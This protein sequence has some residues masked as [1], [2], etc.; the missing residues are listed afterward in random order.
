[1]ISL[2]YRLL[3]GSCVDG[4]RN[5][6]YGPPMAKVWDASLPEGGNATPLLADSVTAL[7]SSAVGRVVVCGSHAGRF[8]A[9]VAARKQVRG[10]VL[11]DAGV[12]LDRAGIAGLELLADLGV[13]AVTV[14]KD[15]AHIGDARDSLDRGIVSHLNDTA[16]ALGC[17]VGMPV[18]EAI[19]HLAA[20]PLASSTPPAIEEARHLLLDGKPRVWA[21]DS[22]SLAS[23]DDAGDILVTGS[24]GR[25]LGGRPETALRVAATAALFNDA[26]DIEGCQTGRLAALAERGIAAAAVG[27]NTARIGDARS[28]YFD[29]VISTVNSVAADRGAAV[30]QSAWSFVETILGRGAVLPEPVTAEAP[31]DQHV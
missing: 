21:L 14:S 10:I 6:P 16:R 1:M 23:P 24:H 3:S 8:A 12:G 18:A 15:S 29:G 25:L 28:T 5:P 22:A 9:A 2:A 27:V 20:A 30:G 13:P 19:G 4:R 31:H 26:G 17:R 11:N 7:A